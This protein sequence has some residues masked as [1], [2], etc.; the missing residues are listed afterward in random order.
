M[1]LSTIETSTNL[2]QQ[3]ISLFEAQPT[4][5]QIIWT[6]GLLFFGLWVGYTALLYIGKATRKHKKQ[7]NKSLSGKQKEITDDYLFSDIDISTIPKTLYNRP[8][9]RELFIQLLTQYQRSFKGREATK[10]AHIYTALNLTSH[11][12]AKLKSRKYHVIIQGIQELSRMNHP[13]LSNLCMPFIH[14]R[15]PDLANEAQIH[16]INQ[17]GF[18]A[19]GIFENYTKPISRW[20][21]I[22]ILNRLKG[23]HNFDEVQFSPLLNSVNPDVVLLAIKVITETGRFSAAEKVFA[24]RKAVHPQVRKQ[25]YICMK[26]LS[27]SQLTNTMHAELK[28]E[29]NPEVKAAL[30][31]CLGSFAAHTTYASFKREIEHPQFEVA[32]QAAK[33][34]LRIDATSGSQLAGLSNRARALVERV[35]EE[36]SL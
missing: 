13:D 22:R 31:N 36:A 7:R 20:Q 34:L 33:G 19:L 3:A 6:I 15:Q 26:K 10:I 9:K 23:F 30:L 8:Y 32:Y 18:T 28:T 11:S 1:D 4:E 12:L 2:L 5:I 35:K 14:A 17:Y 29:Q 24:L 21:Q 27:Q 25:V 16:L